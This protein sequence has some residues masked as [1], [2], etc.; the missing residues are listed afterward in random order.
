MKRFYSD[1]LYFCLFAATA[2][3]AAAPLT[4]DLGGATTVAITGERAFRSIAANAE[5]MSQARFTF[6][7]QLFNTFWEPAPGSQPTTDGLGPVFNRAACSDCHSNNG[8]GRPPAAGGEMESMLVRLSLAGTGTHGEPVGVPGYGD[9]LQDRAVETIPPEGKAVLSWT[10]VPGTYA[11]GTAYSLR[12]PALRFDELAFGAL[13]DHTLTSARIASP[14]IGL[15][16]LEAVPEATLNDLAD[17]DD[18]DKDG[19]SG[20]MNKV[21]DAELQQ[22]R[23]GRFG[24]K[25]NQPSLRQQNAGAAIGDMGLTSPVFCSRT[26][27]PAHGS[28]TTAAW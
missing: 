26:P 9:Q 10:E 25:A 4:P 28:F 8:R 24:W 7:Q 16:L 17:P 19:I 15:G 2:T 18:A 20:R 1:S 23:T 5:G 22:T 27:Q 3:V 21:W 14:L 12:Q 13:P 6:G 11:D